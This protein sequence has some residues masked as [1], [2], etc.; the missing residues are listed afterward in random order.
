MD[1]LLKFFVIAGN[2]NEYDEFCKR[3]IR[4]QTYP[5]RYFVYVNSPDSLRGFSDIE[6]ACTGSWKDRPD[7]YELIN[8]LKTSVT[9]VTKLQNIFRLEEEL[10]KHM[11][12]RYHNTIKYTYE[13][14]TYIPVSSKTGIPKL[15]DYE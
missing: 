12:K 2:R 7:V 14:P 4:N 3:A 8:I 5:N 11:A 9:G 15:T 13:A 1:G 6:G 10:G